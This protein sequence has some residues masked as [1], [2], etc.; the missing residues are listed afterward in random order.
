M[1]LFDLEEPN[2]LFYLDSDDSGICDCENSLF[3]YS[4]ET[5]ECYQQN[6]QVFF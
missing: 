1:F 6:S 3:I 4:A 2:Q 5:G